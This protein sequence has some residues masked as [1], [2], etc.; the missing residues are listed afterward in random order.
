MILINRY[1]TKNKPLSIYSFQNY[2]TIP[3]FEKDISWRC[4]I[5]R[6]SYHGQINL[7]NELEKCITKTKSIEEEGIKNVITKKGVFKLILGQKQILILFR[8]K[9]FPL[10]SVKMKKNQMHIMTIKTIKFK[11]RIT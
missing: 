3:F 11:S 1:K 6:D 10:L 5:L 7:V 2:E 4:T 9:L 8:N